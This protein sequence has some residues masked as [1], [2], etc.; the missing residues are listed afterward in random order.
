MSQ[1]QLNTHQELLETIEKIWT[2]Y[3]E[4]RLAQLLVNAIKPS[5]PCSEMYH[6]QDSQLI[7]KLELFMNEHSEKS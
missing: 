3:P 2:K 6:I 4:L 5:E 1:A 7:N